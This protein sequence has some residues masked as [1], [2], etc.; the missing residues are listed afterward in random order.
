[1][2][3]RGMVIVVH[4]QSVTDRSSK[5]VDD[6]VYRTDNKFERHIELKSRLFSIKSVHPESNFLCPRNLDSVDY[7]FELSFS[8]TSCRGNESRDTHPDLCI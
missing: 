8:R 6:D 2:V 4:G 7:F 3:C 1:M 5:F